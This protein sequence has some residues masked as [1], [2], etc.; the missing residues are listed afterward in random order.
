M[1]PEDRDRRLAAK[2]N[3][4]RVKLAASALNALSIG[5]AGAAFVLPAI[6]AQGVHWVWL[7]AA[8]A[9][10]FCGQAVFRFMK[11]ED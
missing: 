4:E 7:P 9:L 6:T 8:L 5:T 1:T 3:N 2:R 10:H 11:S